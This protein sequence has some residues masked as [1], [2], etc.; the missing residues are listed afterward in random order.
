M[1]AELT[2]RQWMDG[3][4]REIDSDGGAWPVRKLVGYRIAGQL[5]ESAGTLYMKHG[6][7]MANL[8]LIGFSTICYI[9]PSD[10]VGLGCCSAVSLIPQLSVR[11]MDLD[12]QQWVG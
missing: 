5:G 11:S 1:D 4:T 6:E 7:F 9:D 10:L 12:P 3:T 8:A 2:V